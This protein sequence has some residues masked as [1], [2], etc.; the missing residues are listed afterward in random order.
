MT[1]VQADIQASIEQEAAPHKHKTIKR[2]AISTGDESQELLTR[3][4]MLLTAKKLSYRAISLIGSA[5]ESLVHKA[6]EI[7]ASSV[8]RLSLY[9]LYLSELDW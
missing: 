7:N 3:Y 4:A 2:A 9:Q 8:V 1:A 6:K 5:K